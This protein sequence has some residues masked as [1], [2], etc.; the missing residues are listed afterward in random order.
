MK[1][2]ELIASLVADSRPPPP[3]WAR[4]ISLAAGAGALA[5][6]VIFLTAL[7][8]H[9]D[10]TDAFVSWRFDLKL[11]LVALALVLAL[12]DA[13][14]LADPTH[15]RFA[16]WLSWIL[17]LAVVCAALI[18]L[19]VTPPQDWLVRLVGTNWLVCLVAIPILS[20]APLVTGLFALRLGA[21]AS[22]EKAGAA[23]GRLAAAMAAFIYAL[24]CIDDSPLFVA[25]W[26][27]IATF[28]VIAIGALAGRFALRW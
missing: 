23:L 3:V 10:L 17:P 12:N 14:G 21:P 27:T 2:D 26:Y 9:P 8:F 11:A 20:M 5:S 6:A 1:T 7:G 28:A 24:H 13:V 25:V 22:A 4:S 18:E 15:R 19:S 16:S